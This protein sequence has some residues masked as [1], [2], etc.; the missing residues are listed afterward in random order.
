MT[1]HASS[2]SASR[3]SPSRLF[4][5]A[6][7]RRTYRHLAYL[8]LRFPLGIAAFVVF[9]TGISLGVALL[10]LLVG[11]P[12][13][14]G[15]LG[16]ADHAGVVEAELATRL[17]GRD[18]SWGPIDPTDLPLTE[19]ARAVA[20][21][22][23]AY[24]LLVWFFASFFV[25]IAAFVGVVTVFATALVLA[26][27]PL[28]YWLP[29]VQYAIADGAG[30][31]LGTYAIDTLPEALVAS[32]VGVALVILGLHAVNL[33]ARGLGA[34]VEALLTPPQNR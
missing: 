27:A 28:V 26:I 29:S 34:V 6:T 2:S 17:L 33:A 3:W 16:L 20:T 31:P 24:L 30:G 32:V 1:D 23:R 13:L 19:Y 15:V 9:V 4:G 14:V 5:V 7:E 12:L 25:G 22:P 10:I 21:D 11:L 18:V 8:L